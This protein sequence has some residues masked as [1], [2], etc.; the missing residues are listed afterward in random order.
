VVNDL[1][2]RIT[3]ALNIGL[4]VVTLIATMVGLFP[5]GGS[6]GYIGV[7]TTALLLLNVPIGSG[8]YSLSGAGANARVARSSSMSG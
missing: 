5:S 4:S 7:A 2:G 3:A 6:D 1:R 8:L